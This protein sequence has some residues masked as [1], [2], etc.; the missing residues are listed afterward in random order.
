MTASFARI[1]LR[2]NSDHRRQ[3][4][5]CRWGHG[6]EAIPGVYRCDDHKRSQTRCVGRTVIDFDRSLAKSSLRSGY[7]HW[8]VRPGRC[9]RSLRC[10]LEQPRI[11]RAI[12]AAPAAFSFETSTIVKVFGCRPHEGGA[13]H[14]GAGVRKP[15]HK[16][17]KASGPEDRTA[18]WRQTSTI[19]TFTTITIRRRS[20][21][22]AVGAA[23]AAVAPAAAFWLA[24]IGSVLPKAVPSWAT[25]FARKPWRAGAPCLPAWP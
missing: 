20:T 13:A 15:S 23:G 6:T 19:T 17:T 18:A 3:L 22:T 5:L 9:C 1:S 4:L 12:T 10:A 21:A 7:R 14:T 11:P 24:A 16:R 2:P 25:R 8:P